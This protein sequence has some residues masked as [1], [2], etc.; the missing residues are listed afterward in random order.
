M[1]KIWGNVFHIVLVFFFLVVTN[2][3][4]RTSKAYVEGNTCNNNELLFSL[5]LNHIDHII[6]IPSLCFFNQPQK[7]G[8]WLFFRQVSDGARTKVIRAP[9]SLPIYLPYCILLPVFLCASTSTFNTASWE[10]SVFC[11][12]K[13]CACANLKDIFFF[14]NLLIADKSRDT[15]LCICTVQVFSSSENHNSKLYKIWHLYFNLH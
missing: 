4:M 12:G 6:I 5:L 7:I 2:S 8:K 1:A 11:K 15:L 10:W 13:S 3:S 14:P 9:I